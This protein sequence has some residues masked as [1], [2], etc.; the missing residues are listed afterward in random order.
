MEIKSKKELIEYKNKI[1]QKL[2]KIIK[3]LKNNIDN[4]Y[5]FY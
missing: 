1:T 3:N 5:F 4:I 2:S